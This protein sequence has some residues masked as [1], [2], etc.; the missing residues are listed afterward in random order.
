MHKDSEVPRVLLHSNLSAALVEMTNKGFGMTTVVD[1]DNH[2]LGVFTDGDLRRAVD[3]RI[4]IGKATMADV[5]HPNPT[6]IHKDILAAEALGIMEHKKI[7]ALIV[8]NDQQPIGVIHMHDIL[9][10]GVV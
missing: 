6:T 10:A 5:M 3:Q 8:E 1:T 2:L 7:T 4:D 9:R